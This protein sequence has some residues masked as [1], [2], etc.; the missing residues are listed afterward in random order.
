VSPSQ[1]LVVGHRHDDRDVLVVASDHDRGSLC[2]IKNRVELAPRVR[3]GNSL[4]AQAVQPILA[5]KGVTPELAGL[6][7]VT[8]ARYGCRV[9]AEVA[10]WDRFKSNSTK[11]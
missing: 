7:A 6:G 5:L 3:F 9:E 11:I 2:F 10:S 1:P 8:T 4:H